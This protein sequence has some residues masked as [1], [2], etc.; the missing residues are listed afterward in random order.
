M[1]SSLSS[2]SSLFLSECDA[3]VWFGS[4]VYKYLVIALLLLLLLILS[5][6]NGE[7]CNCLKQTCDHLSS[8]VIVG[9]VVIVVRDDVDVNGVD[10]NHI[11]VVALCAV[12][13]SAL[14]LILAVVDCLV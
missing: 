1:G 6:F 2:I 12:T 5:R 14:S 9:H 10:E 13:C 4:S 7:G 11:M 8:I 3:F